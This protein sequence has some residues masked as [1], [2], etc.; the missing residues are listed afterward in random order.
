VKRRLEG[1][2]PS[3]NGQAPW[4]PKAQAG[5]LTHRALDGR[6]LNKRDQVAAA[7]H[8]HILC[9]N[10]TG[11]FATSIKGGYVFAANGRRVTS[12]IASYL[13]R[14]HAKYSG[15]QEGTVA[16][17]IPEL[18]KANPEWFGICLA[19]TDGHVYAIGDTDIP[20]TI[21]S[22]SKPFA[23]GLALEDVG[24]D[25]V[26]AKIG[27]EPTGDAFNS[28]SLAPGTGRP[29][30]PMINAGAI[31]ATSLV[32]GVS[33]DDRLQRLLSV[34][35]LY[36]GRALTLDRAVYESER[37]TGHRNRA[38]GHMLRNFDILNDD[39]DPALDLYFQQC[40]VAV[41][42]H[43]L[44]VMAA[45]LANGGIN[46]VTHERAV[47]SD[48]VDSILG[49]MTTCGMYD[50]AGEWVYRVGLPAKSGVAGGII[51]V[52]PGQLGIGVFSPRLDARGNSV[53]GVKVCTDLSRD[54]NLHCLRVPR[55]ARAVIRA[56]H[57]VGEISS[58][59]V[60]S[61]RERGIL[62]QAGGRA[63]LYELQ[64]DVGFAAA[65]VVV[66]AVVEAGDALD[67]A[68]VDWKRVT[69]VEPSAALLFS[70]LA[71]EFARNGKQLCFVHAEAHQRFV[72][73]VEEQLET[74]EALRAFPDAD[75]GLEWCEA[76]IL[77]AHGVTHHERPLTLGEHGLCRGLDAIAI[78][79]L[80]RVLQR[81]QFARGELIVRKGDPADT[82]YLLMLGEVSVVVELPDGRNQ[83]LSTL[84]AG[85]TF[86]EL[87]VI[88][89]TVRS[90]DVQADT[91]ATCYALSTQ[92]FDRLG[93]TR[94][95]IKM[96]VLENL[97]RN[98]ARMV[99][100]LNQEVTNLAG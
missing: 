12:P 33:G 30:N 10:G 49:V 14:L 1:I 3:F 80:E 31:A 65:E 60:R 48:L 18:A 76:R 70:A 40:S 87:A 13:D 16:T 21:Q 95:A 42:C 54:F 75:R 56:Q 96:V 89:R 100:R 25:G 93:E 61:E 66:R 57:A 20:F 4:L 37:A 58:K 27:V 9:S 6:S 23:Y 59:R 73:R 97:L 7:L 85:M 36:A 64:G 32:K 71:E 29:F 67:I 46:P 78:A 81:H 11:A 98:V 84:S 91:A 52:L 24:H 5:L 88:D 47:R 8:R 94:P 34:F 44:S 68:L 41:T 86:G 28:I 26:L 35:S 43:D 2:P 22:I 72:R 50:Y 69:H 55:A 83:R 45:T 77:A 92:A 53:R 17:Y 82:M 99:V 62:D 15:L 51:A 19:T 74:A 79:D 38:I 90:A 39:P 63:T